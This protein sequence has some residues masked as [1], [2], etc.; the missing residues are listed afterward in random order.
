MKRFLS[1]CILLGSAGAAFGSTTIISDDFESYAN[2]AAFE[3]AWPKSSPAGNSLQLSSAD[4]H[5]PTKS[6]FSEGNLAR[7]NFRNFGQ[8]VGLLVGESL[9]SEFWMTLTADTTNMRQYCEVRGYAGA[10]LDPNLTG[11]GTLQELYALGVTNATVGGAARFQARVAFG[12]SA[13]SS[14]ADAA[15]WFNLDL[16]GTPTRSAGWHKMRIEVVRGVA[17]TTV[18]FYVDDVLGGYATD[19]SAS[20][21]LDSFVLGSGLTS[22]T[23]RNSYY[24]DVNVSIVPE[25]AGLALL[26][27]AAMLMRRGR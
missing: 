21:T 3:A 18:N 1:V 7:R 17:S 5:S 15:G 26:G 13:F 4:S 23:T 2:Q 24:D 22:N 8:E 16:S 14:T 20:N 19:T 10:G 11:G 27:L 6:A 25:P 12:G 9:V